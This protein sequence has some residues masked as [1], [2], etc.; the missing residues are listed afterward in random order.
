MLRN[1]WL[2]CEAAAFSTAMPAWQAESADL[3][4]GHVLG[5]RVLTAVSLDMWSLANAVVR[6]DCS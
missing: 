5:L 4:T 1:V 6:S 3:G 2:V